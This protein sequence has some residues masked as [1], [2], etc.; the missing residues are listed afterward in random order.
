VSE[1]YAHNGRKKR[2]K[3]TILWPVEEIGELAKAIRGEEPENLGEE[4]AVASFG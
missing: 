1:L 4:L 3:V 2:G